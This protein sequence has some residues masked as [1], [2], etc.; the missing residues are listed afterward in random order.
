MAGGN[1]EVGV[2]D[3]GEEG[4]GEGAGVCFGGFGCDEA[5]I[6]GEI[7]VVSLFGRL[8]FDGN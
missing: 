8:D 1:L 3:G 7:A 6:G 5:E 2:E 4:F